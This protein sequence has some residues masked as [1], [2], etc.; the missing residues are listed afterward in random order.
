MAIIVTSSRTELSVVL[1]NARLLGV[2][3]INSEQAA[4]FIVK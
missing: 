4:A 2:L 1:T 3:K